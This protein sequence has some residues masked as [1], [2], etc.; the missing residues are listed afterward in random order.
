MPSILL[1]ENS[2]TIR[3][4]LQE[5]IEDRL[6]FRVVSAPDYAAAEEILARGEHDFFLGL[7]DLDL[8]DAPVGAIVDLVHSRGIHSI[9]LTA[10]LRGELRE[11]IG[12][13]NIID[14]VDKTG[15]ENLEYLPSL[16]RR[17]H[18]NR[19]IDVLVVDGDRS[20]REH[21]RNE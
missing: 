19:S 11:E 3:A 10:D 21:E 4:M 14:S 9:V 17:I 18:L 12:S 1:V 20:C 16:I 6:G 13:K 2:R 8:P 15:V 7:L 5:R